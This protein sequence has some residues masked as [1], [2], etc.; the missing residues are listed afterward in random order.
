MGGS[1]PIFGRHLYRAGR[2]IGKLCAMKPDDAEYATYAFARRRLRVRPPSSPVLYRNSA[3]WSQVLEP[4]ENRGGNHVF[5]CHGTTFRV[6][7][8]HGKGTFFRAAV[9][10]NLTGVA[11]PPFFT[12]GDQSEP[13]KSIRIVHRDRIGQRF[14]MPSPKPPGE[15]VGPRFHARLLRGRQK[16]G[17]VVRGEIFQTIRSRFA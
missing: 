7:M 1:F 4:A 11:R 17:D 12:F 10:L 16:T 2:K 6:Q 14:L 3:G 5:S 15:I 13:K 8:G 9:G